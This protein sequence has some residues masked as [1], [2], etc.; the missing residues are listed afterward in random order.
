MKMND[1]NRRKRCKATQNPFLMRKLT[2]FSRFFSLDHF[3]NSRIPG[4]QR[5]GQSAHTSRK[6]FRPTISCDLPHGR[7]G[8]SAPQPRELRRPTRGAPAVLGCVEGV[9]MCFYLLFHL[10]YDWPQ[11]TVGSWPSG[12]TV[13]AR[14]GAPAR[15][16]CDQRPHSRERFWYR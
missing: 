10:F 1:F 4:S 9:R 13:N 14:R 8:S 5:T 11:P 3:Q 2:I 16:I 7:R 15:D 12:A 6:G